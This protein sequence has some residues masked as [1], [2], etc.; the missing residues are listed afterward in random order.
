MPP[1]R[2]AQARAHRLVAEIYLDPP[3][4]SLRYVGA[5]IQALGITAFVVPP[6]LAD[7][8]VPP[9]VLHTM[10]KRWFGRF[11]QEDRAPNVLPRISRDDLR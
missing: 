6:P 7:V 11:I 8:V 5:E 1:V 3:R 10:A 9:T 2:A 4:P